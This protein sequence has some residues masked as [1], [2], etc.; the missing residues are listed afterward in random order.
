MTVNVIRMIIMDRG[1][2]EYDYDLDYGQKEDEEG[3]G[4]AE[5]QSKWNM[6]RGR[7]AWGMRDVRIDFQHTYSMIKLIES[8]IG[9]T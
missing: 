3:D 9:G 7:D 4:W 6:K 2:Y 5:C 1:D 8:G